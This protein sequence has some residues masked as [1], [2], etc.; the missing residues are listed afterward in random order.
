M[1]CIDTSSLIAYLE[2]QAG[3]DVELVDQAFGDRVGVIAPVILTEILSDGSLAKP[4][5][6]AILQLPLLAI[7]DGY[8]ERAGLLRARILKSGRKAGLADTLIAQSCLDHRAT[9]VSRDRDFRV[10]HRLAGLRL[11]EPRRT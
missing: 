7:A 5:R 10:F 3:E 8:W 11:L 6:E 2:G 9:L 1:L 4:V